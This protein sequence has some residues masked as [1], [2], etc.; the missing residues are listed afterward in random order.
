MVELKV[1]DSETIA[2]LLE[3]IYTEQYDYGPEP[4]ISDI[5][6]LALNA[7]LY[8]A[9]DFYA[10]DSLKV[11]SRFKFKSIADTVQSMPGFEKIASEIPTLILLVYKNSPPSDADNATEGLRGPLLDLILRNIDSLLEQQKSTSPNLADVLEECGPF[12]RDFGLLMAKKWMS[13][14]AD[15][16]GF[17][18][19]QCHCNHLWADSRRH[20]TASCPKCNAKYVW[21]SKS[22]D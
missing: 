2:K 4:N 6:R 7:K 22:S 19:F 14:K 16:K 11:V 13:L 15:W 17:T 5:Q 10:I 1:G 21:E 18:K 3:Y 20:F 12:G 8:I 9:A